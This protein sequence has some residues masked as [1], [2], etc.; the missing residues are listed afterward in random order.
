MD[1][2][3]FAV[4]HHWVGP[5]EFSPVFG[6]YTNLLSSSSRFD[7]VVSRDRLRLGVQA[8]GSDPIRCFGDPSPRAVCWFGE[9]VTAIARFVG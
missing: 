4:T 8:S 2:P 5:A 1:L 3:L 7:D 9:W 6:V